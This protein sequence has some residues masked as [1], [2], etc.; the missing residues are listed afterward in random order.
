MQRHP[1]RCLRLTRKAAAR[2]T[3]A[4]TAIAAYKFGRGDTMSGDDVSGDFD[5]VSDVIDE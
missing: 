4:V 5:D 3:A 2:A 1:H